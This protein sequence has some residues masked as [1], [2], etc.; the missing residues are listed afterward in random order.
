MAILNRSQK[1]K[2]HDVAIGSA[3][4]RAIHPLDVP[5]VH[6]AQVR[7]EHVEMGGH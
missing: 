3:V 6:C 1:M 5:R 4:S 2:Q 7:L